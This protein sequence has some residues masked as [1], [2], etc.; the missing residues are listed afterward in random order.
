M[1]TKHPQDDVVTVPDAFPEFSCEASGTDPLT[2]T[3][4]RNTIELTNDPGG[5]PPV[6]VTIVGNT[7]HLA[8]G[9]PPPSYDGSTIYCNVTNPDGTVMSDAATLT[10]QS[11]S[12]MTFCFL[13]FKDCAHAAKLH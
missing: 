1:I 11:K 10:V 5:T 7:A 9:D 13:F 6:Y 12:T 8:I 3:W 4:F 2:F